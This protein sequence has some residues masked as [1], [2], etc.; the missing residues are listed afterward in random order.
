MFDGEGKNKGGERIDLGEERIDLGEDR[1][2]LGGERKSVVVRENIWV[3]IG[4]NLG[5]KRTGL[6]GEG[7][8]FGSKGKGLCSEKKR[9]IW[10]ERE[11]DLGGGRRFGW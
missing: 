6:A 9:Q 10:V 4:N 3:L 1:E 11:Q 5:S 2:D 7:K 8:C